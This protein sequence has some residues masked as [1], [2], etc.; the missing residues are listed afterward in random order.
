MLVGFQHYVIMLGTIVLIATILVPQMGGG[1][2]SVPAFHSLSFECVCKS[3]MC[4]RVVCF[5]ITPARRVHHYACNPYNRI[6]K[7]S[8]LKIRYTSI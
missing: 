6:G 4:V 5:R 2:V 1:Y 7:K 8:L 3:R